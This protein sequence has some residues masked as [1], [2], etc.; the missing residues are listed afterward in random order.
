M[1]TTYAAMLAVALG[2]GMVA[3]SQE[4]A[5]KTKDAAASATQDVKKAGEDAGSKAADIGDKIAD[6]TKDIAGK[7]AEKTGEIAGKVATKT[8][9]AGEAT[10]EAVTDSWI[11]AKIKT[12]FADEKALEGSHI[13]V[14]T[15]D[16]VVTLKGTVKTAAAKT[17]AESLAS[18]T[19]GVTKVINQLAV[20]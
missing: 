16:H 8:K 20:K 17:R 18:G 5:D 6:K 9:E 19:K 15:A 3:C 11:T 4:T 13:N 12:K 7:T 14:D 2:L 1:K 10:A